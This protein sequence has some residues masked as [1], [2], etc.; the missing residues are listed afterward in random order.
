VL[1]LAMTGCAT[2]PL[3]QK[4][5]FDFKTTRLFQKPCPVPDR[6]DD[7]ATHQAR[8]SGPV[9]LV[10]E[11]PRRQ[12]LET[13]ENRCN[14]TYLEKMVENSLS[15][16][17]A[18]EKNAVDGDTIEDVRR[19]GFTIH[20]G[21]DPRVSRPNTRALH[22]NDALAAAGMGVSAPPLQKPD[23]IKAYIEFMS[24]HYGEEYLEKDMKN[25]TDRFCLSRRETHELGADRVF[26]IV[27]RNGRV[28][29]RII[30]GGLVDNPKQE[31]GFL[32]C[33][34]DFIVETLTGGARGALRMIAP[35][36]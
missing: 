11:K 3:L 26:T 28:I 2:A 27:W 5:S 7:G 4:Q 36:P 14:E 17:E 35:L 25:V 22:G 30:K 9:A 29:K 12:A 32:I 19:K 20:V 13:T 34:G 1:A 31:R 15:I 23:E 24:A 16:R 33:P 21:G 10:V 6:P 18:D 8:V